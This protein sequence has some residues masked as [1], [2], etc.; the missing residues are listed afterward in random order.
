MRNKWFFGIF[1]SILLI[2]SLF[3]G[4]SLYLQ[5]RSSSNEIN[6]FV[7]VD[8][9]FTSSENTKLLI[10][11]IKSYTNFFVIGSTAITWNA[12]RL[13]E[14]CQYLNDSGLYFATY[15][16]PSLPEYN[17]SDAEWIKEARQKWPSNFFGLYAY[18]E[19]GGYQIDR[20]QYM[21]V[22]EADNY[23]DAANKFVANVGSWLNEFRYDWGVGDFP[24]VTSDYVLYDF[25]YKAGYDAVFAEFGWN[26]SRPLNV[27]LCRGAASMQNKDW[28]VMITWKYDSTPYIESRQELYDDMVYAY[29]NGAKYILVFD[30]P[31]NS[32]FGIL[33]NQHLDALKQFWQY[34]KDNPRTTNSVEGR[35]AYVLPKNYG[36]GFRMPN[37]KIWGLWEADN[38]SNKIWSDTNSLLGQYKDKLDIIYEDH[39]G[40]NNALYQKLIFWNGTILERG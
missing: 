1:F 2:A 32:T 36:F 16:H 10:N 20:S 9:V 33:K 3:V 23:T 29:E 5:T 26:H 7:G 15:I 40:Q 24:L 37:D 4:I 30:Y 19:A 17:F 18:D 11:E 35:V 38:Q 6:L 34:I 31:E 27:A 8:A 14:V 22:K 25:D 12:T 39:V 13:N 28:G 21:V